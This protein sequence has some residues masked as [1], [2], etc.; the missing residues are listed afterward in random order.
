MLLI[1]TIN[2][3]Y[4]YKK[5]YTV[6]NA[7]TYTFTQN[8]NEAIVI[9]AAKDSADTYA[10]SLQSC[11]AAQFKNYGSSGAWYISTDVVYINKPQIGDKITFS[12]G[13]QNTQISV[14]AY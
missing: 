9:C 12:F 8:Y 6:N 14:Y 13:G 3:S 2:S 11:T 7:K 4:E 1:I 10:V 5:I